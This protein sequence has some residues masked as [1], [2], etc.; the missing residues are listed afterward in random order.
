[1]LNVEVN[2]NFHCGLDPQSQIKI[3]DVLGSEI[4]CLVEKNQFDKNNFHFSISNL[5]LSSGVY[6][7]K[8]SCA[9]DRRG[10]S[11]RVKFIKQ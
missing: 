3:T 7:V 6:F 1:V 10:G 9:G 5:Q 11:K 8:V 2:P 4:N